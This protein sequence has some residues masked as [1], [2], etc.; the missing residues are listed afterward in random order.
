MEVNRHNRI[1]DRI[2]VTSERKDATARDFREF[3][4]SY[5]CTF[6]F[7]R[8]MRELDEK[9]RRLRGQIAGLIQELRKLS[10][11]TDT[12]H[13]VLNISRAVAFLLE[14]R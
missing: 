13:R 12:D 5:S 9:R 4:E 10:E 3:T 2:D 8:N 14:G 11:L 7:K 1:D 6:L